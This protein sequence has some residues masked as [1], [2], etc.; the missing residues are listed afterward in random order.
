[1]FTEFLVAL[2]FLKHLPSDILLRL[3]TSHFYLPSGEIARMRYDLERE[4]GCHI[5]TYNLAPAV[6]VEHQGLHLC[7]ILTPA[8][9]NTTQLHRLRQA[10][11][12][13]QGIGVVIV[14]YEKPLRV[15]HDAKTEI[16]KYG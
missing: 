13:F 14:A 1:M 2:P 3:D 9:L 15:R 11:V 4:C 7:R 16:N 8:C 5:M 6:S 10:E 12:S